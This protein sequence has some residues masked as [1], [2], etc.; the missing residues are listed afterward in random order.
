MKFSEVQPGVYQASVVDWGLEEVEKLDDELKAVIQ[1]EFKVGEE[2]VQGKW[3]GFLKT[4]AGA[5]NK[6]TFTTMVMCG[7]ESD[8]INNFIRG[9]A[10]DMEKKL[11]ITIEKVGEPL[12]STSMHPHP[13]TN[14]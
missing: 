9:D 8:D 14:W 1:F 11:D 12:L 10:L 4:K 3:E 2:S 5:P 6:K 7:F 13:V